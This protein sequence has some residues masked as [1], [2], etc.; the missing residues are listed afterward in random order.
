[1]DIIPSYDIE[2]IN[3]IDYN[4]K[5]RNTILSNLKNYIKLKKLKKFKCYHCDLTETELPDTLIYLDC[6]YSNLKKLPVLPNSLIYLN[7]SCNNLIE[8]PNL[9]NSLTHLNCN[10]NNLR[11]LPKLPNSLISL[12]C[13]SNNL[14]ELPDLPN[15]LTH[16]YCGHN[17]LNINYPNQEIKTINETNSKKR[18]I[19]RMKILNRTLLLEHS[20]MITMNPKRIERL[21][22]NLEIDFFDGSFDTLTT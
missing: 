10:N 22:D 7:C 16:L 17:N 13:Y 5:T 15:S 2:E 20:A 9:P 6:S 21:L 8:L 3:L 19:K 4:D 12:I 18:I 1:M 11:E 14:I